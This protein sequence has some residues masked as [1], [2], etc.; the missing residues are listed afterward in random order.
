MPAAL[1]YAIVLLVAL[2][3]LLWLA[4]VAWRRST[5]ALQSR[6]VASAAPVPAASY[7]ET[8]LEGLPQVVARYFRT[9]LRDGQP[10]VTRARVHWTGEFNMGSPGADR[11]VPF[12]AVQDF[13]PGAPGMV[14]DARM[15]MAP[16]LSVRVRDGFVDRIGSMYGA[17]L[18]V[19]PVVDRQGT[20]D[21]AVASLQRYLAEAT[22]LPTALLPAM[23]VSWQA[24]DE[25]RARATINAGE[26]RA[27]VEFA[28]GADGLVTTMSVPDRVYDDGRTTPAR[29][30]WQGRHLQ[31]GQFDGMVVPSDSVVEWQL[32]TGTYPYW[33]GR[34]AEVEY[35]YADT[36]P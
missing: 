25:G 19:Y 23:G 7:H 17:V 28:F 5:A 34:P 21:M 18:A 30:P 29:H 1:K 31:W 14:W 22:W 26:V 15:R 24:I 13:V 6:L 16:G 2:G 12:T 8:D 3:L 32:P 33:R 11:W 10:L 4:D 27:S 35:A 20:P 9:V 36:Q